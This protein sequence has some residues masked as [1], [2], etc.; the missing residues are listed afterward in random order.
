MKPRFILRYRA[1]VHPDGLGYW[2]EFPEFPSLSRGDKS[3]GTPPEVLAADALAHEIVDLLYQQQSLPMPTP[4]AEG[5]L[6][7]EPR[8]HYPPVMM[9]EG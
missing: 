1:K 5:E 8:F 2:L 7:V 3:G 9:D 4:R 6:Y